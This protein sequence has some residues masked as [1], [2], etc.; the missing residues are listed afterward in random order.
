MDDDL[1]RR[2][3]QV[4]DRLAAEPLD[5]S[6]AAREACL[7]PF[8]F[9]RQF[10][11]LFAQTP[12][13]FATERRL[14]RAKALLLA[15]ELSI[16]EVCLEVGYASVGTFSTRFAREFGLPPQEFRRG[17]RRFWRLGGVRSHRFVPLCF[18][19]NGKIGEVRVPTDTLA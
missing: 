3:A 17:S 9:H 2:L 13:A 5:L 4:R 15:T 14:E 18:M 11:R 6:A 8:H 19:R 12:H 10:V 7:S 1:Q 16:G